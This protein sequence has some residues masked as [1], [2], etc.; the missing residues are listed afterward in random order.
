[1]VRATA[2]GAEVVRVGI[3]RRAGAADPR[4]SCQH[5]LGA[6]AAECAHRAAPFNELEGVASARAL[7]P[8]PRNQRQSSRRYE[9]TQAGALLHTD[10]FPLPKFAQPGHWATGDR[11]A[12]SV[13]AG[14]SVVIGVLDDHTRLVYCELHAAETAEAVS[15]CLRR[16]AAWMREQGC[17]P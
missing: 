16:A 9:W 5:E 8:T 14:K 11:S 12:R 4:G 7:A 10:A 6:D 17:G 3:E 2:A 1:L 13:G 15:A